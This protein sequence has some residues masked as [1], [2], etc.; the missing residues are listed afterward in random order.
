MAASSGNRHGGH[1]APVTVAVVWD[2]PGVGEARWYLD[3][4][5]PDEFMVAL[6]ETAP[7]NWVAVAE[8]VVCPTQ[9]TRRT[10][11][12]V[13][14]ATFESTGTCVLVA[15][16]V[17]GQGCLLRSYDD[18]EV[19]VWSKTGSVAESVRWA[20]FGYPVLVLTG[21]LQ[22]LIS[23]ASPLTTWSGDR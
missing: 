7:P 18:Q 21:G 20:L 9:S 10:A 17:D 2:R 14:V 8:V 11:H 13:A 4:G 22:A 23:G 5:D 1:I 15:A 16:G 6:A 3:G 12:A 19:F